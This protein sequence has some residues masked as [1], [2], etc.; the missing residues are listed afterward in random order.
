MPQHGNS[1]SVPDFVHPNA[2]IDPALAGYFANDASNN[3]ALKLDAMA[4]QN[5]D[6]PT[7][8]TAMGSDL[9]LD[10]SIKPL[11]VEQPRADLLQPAM[12][13]SAFGPELD[14][15]HL[16]AQHDPA[17]WTVWDQESVHGLW[18]MGI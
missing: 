11:P 17:S 3:T 9:F 1:T 15:A 12:P 16:T 14:L 6:S 2:C 18:D 7:L 13:G 10:M 8:G 4:M 5:P